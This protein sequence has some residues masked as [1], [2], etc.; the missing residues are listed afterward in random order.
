MGLSVSA[1]WVFLVCWRKWTRSGEEIMA[2]GT[3]LL[4]PIRDAQ[5]IAHLE[6]SGHVRL[7]RMVVACRDQTGIGRDRPHPA[8]PT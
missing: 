6:V 4:D 7:L 3:W 5:F 1:L 2:G 8:N